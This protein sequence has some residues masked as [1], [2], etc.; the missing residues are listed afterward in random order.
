MGCAC[1]RLRRVCDLASSACGGL[2]YAVPSGL[3]DAVPRLTGWRIPAN[4]IPFA[5]IENCSVGLP[6]QRAFSRLGGLCLGG[7]GPKPF[8]CA[9]VFL[10]TTRG[11][12]DAWAGFA[13][14]RNVQ[15]PLLRPFRAG[16]YLLELTQ[17]VALG[18]GVV[19]LRGGR[20][21]LWWSVMSWAGVEDLEDLED[22]EGDTASARVLCRAA[23]SGLGFICWNSPRALPWAMVW[24]PFGAEDGGCGGASCRGLGL[25]T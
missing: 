1:S 18:Y 16:I 11:R 15:A 19:P 23:L 14:D 6:R 17:G 21:R 9:D 20:W 5:V 12:F 3:R 24:C 10:R 22:L 4:C 8:F 25:R 7:E 13:S 2:R